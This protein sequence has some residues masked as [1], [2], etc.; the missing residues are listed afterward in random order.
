MSTLV[1][2][3]SL[4]ERCGVS[5]QAVSCALRGQGRLSVQTRARIRRAA[6][7]LGYRPN[8]AARGIR[9]GR[10]GAAA[11]LMGTHGGHFPQGMWEGVHDELAGHDMLLTLARI[12][13][14]QLATQDYLPKVIREWSVDGLLVHYAYN[15][16]ASLRQAIADARI[17]A[18]WLNTRLPVDCVSPADLDAGRACTRHLLERG[19][20][21]VAYLF[22]GQLTGHHSEA[23]RRR[24]YELEMR[25]AGLRPAVVEM[26]VQRGPGADG[27]MVDTGFATARAWLGQSPRPTAVVTYSGRTGEALLLAAV[28]LGL[29]IPQDLAITTIENAPANFSGLPLT[30]VVLDVGELGRTAV[31]M[32]LKKIETSRHVSKPVFVPNRLVVGAST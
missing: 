29:R 15:I 32:L 3:K 1:T 18:V 4:A 5:P 21:R 24:G 27:V 7:E 10:F 12:P 13:D 19:H 8:S 31:R 30:T 16:P 20:R 6:E 9:R 28:S 17:P 2:I 26:E 23:D 22:L 25:R 11:L 14:D